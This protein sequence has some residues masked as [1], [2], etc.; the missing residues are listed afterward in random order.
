MKTINLLPQ[1][2]LALLAML[3][4]LACKGQPDVFVENENVIQS[5]A[6]KIEE[7]FE[8]YAHYGKFN[9]A[10]LVAQSGE[11]LYEKAF[12]MANMEWDIANQTD[13]KFR[14][15]S[16]TKQFTAMLIMQLCAEGKLD[17]HTPIAHYLPN[18][19]QK[20]AALITVHHL[21]T[22]TAG[23][24]EMDAFV[25]YRDIERNRYTPQELM[26]IFAEGA[27]EFTPASSFA[28]SNPGYVVLGVIIEKLRGKSYEEV[29]NENILQPLGMH[30]SGYDKHWTVLKNRASGY[31]PM[32]ERGQYVNVNYVDMSVP[33]AAGAM[34]AT[35]EDLY[36]WDQALYTD[37]L[38]PQAY[39]DSLFKPY[40]AAY[41]S[42]YAYG[43]FVGDTDIGNTGETIYAM[44]HS[45]GINGF[46][47]RIT[48]I[49]SSKS[50]VI[51]L[52]NSER[53]PL[54]EL[55]V[56]INAILQNKSYN[57]KKSVAYSLLDFIEKNKLADATSYYNKIKSNAD[58]YIDEHE[59]NKAG[60]ELLKKEKVKAAALF[61]KLNVAA[62][63]TAFNAY[64]SYG[65]VLL[66][67]GKKEEAIENY[68]KSLA[69]NP[70]NRNAI[71]VL[72]DLGV[73]LNN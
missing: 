37:K 23:I 68:K 58:Y 19:P 47:S 8:R 1:M 38:L 56:A 25:N 43:W 63:P 46:R 36:L 61:F 62:F 70:K 67:E 24:A 27:L 59:M 16:I 48:R 12:G 22:H 45:G 72:T 32:Y 41:G 17:L 54:R 71:K 57:P 14:I 42:H 39:V 35:V 11:L 5:K 6:E 55:T 9:G 44:S 60:Y 69:L 73:P 66:L 7:L 34:Y 10:V 51:L 49:P 29:L 15:A 30:N 52:S 4:M 50:V 13:T 31:S 21:L 33:Y 3:F 40:V 26:D 53:A 18:Y 2:P 65:E 20:N 28:Y 64:D